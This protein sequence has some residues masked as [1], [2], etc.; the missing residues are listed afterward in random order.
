M[1]VTIAL[2]LLT[3]KLMPVILPPLVQWAKEW[4]TQHVPKQ[5]IPVLLAAGGALVDAAATYLGVDGIPADLPMLGESA[6]EGALLGLSTVGL[7]EGV[8][9]AREWLKARSAK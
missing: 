6:W 5:L 9:R 3:S 7:Y 1:I 4:V 2:K 8:T